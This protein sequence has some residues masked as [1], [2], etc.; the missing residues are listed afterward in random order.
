MEDDRGDELDLVLDRA[1]RSYSAEEPWPGLEERVEK[2]ARVQAPRHG[3][4]WA[5]AAAL[6]AVPVL[7][8]LAVMIVQRRVQPLQPVASA[9]APPPMTAVQREPAT[10]G[11][12]KAS[13]PV[14][15]SLVQAKLPKAKTFPEVSAM[16][17]EER[18][19]VTLAVRL[20]PEVREMAM[21][22]PASP[23]PIR[24]EGLK[25][26]QLEESR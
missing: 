24:I 5:W 8:V 1:L 10:P 4:Q 17:A 15:P 23:E 12:P 21:A 16:T 2:R 14:R 18:A 7:V 6:A 25:I 20:P 9:P 26:E 19:L 11:A 22:A 3:F 13:H